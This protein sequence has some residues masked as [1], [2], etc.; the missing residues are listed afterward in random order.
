MNIADVKEGMV[1][2]ATQDIGYCGGQVEEDK[3]EENEIVT[4]DRVLPNPFTNR[5]EFT[6]KEH[7]DRYGPWPAEYFEPVSNEELKCFDCHGYK[8]GCAECAD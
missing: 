7:A 3:I 8:N 4:V 1:L 6:L 5:V 2:R